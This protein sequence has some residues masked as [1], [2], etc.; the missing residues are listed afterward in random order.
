MRRKNK[1]SVLI[2][3][4]GKYIQFIDSLIRS[5]EKN[6]FLGSEKNYF[7]FTDSVE[8][9]NIEGANIE[10]IEQ[11]KLGWPYDTM[12]RFHMFLSIKE[13]IQNS[14]FTFFLNANMEFL[15]E[16][17][18]E[19]LP[20]RNKTFFVGVKHPGFFKLPT[21]LMP[22][23]SRRES[24]FFVPDEGNRNKM[25]YQ[26]CFNGGESS[27]WIEMCEILSERIDKDLKSNIIPIWHDE[28]AINWYFKDIDLISLEPNYA[29]PEAVLSGNFQPASTNNVHCYH[30]LTDVKPYAVQRDKGNHGGS[31]FLRS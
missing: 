11:K 3:A 1:I 2:I 13:K 25:Y 31:D 26:G 4:T 29:I 15:N 9:I 12:M 21:F 22:Y 24:S 6:F 18:E 23:E 8:E 19:I 27:K 10:K 14:D 30:Y 17:G 20:D 5:A 28:S 7:V 16:V